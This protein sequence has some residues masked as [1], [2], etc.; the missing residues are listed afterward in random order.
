MITMK[1][2]AD[3]FSAQGRVQPV[4]LGGAISVIFSSQLS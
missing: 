4:R 1:R 2:S 3:V